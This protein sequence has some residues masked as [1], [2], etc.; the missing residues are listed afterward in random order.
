MDAYE[1]V[2]CETGDPH[3]PASFPIADQK[4]YTAAREMKMF[5]NIQ[6]FK[7]TIYIHLWFT[8]FW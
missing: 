1:N 5:V 4:W 6:K 7:A 8:I 2:L 3:G